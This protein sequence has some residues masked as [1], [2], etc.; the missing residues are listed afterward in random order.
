MS[1]YRRDPLNSSNKDAFYDVGRYR[2]GF[3][4]V[5]LLASYLNWRGIMPTGKWGGLYTKAFIM[6]MGLSINLLAM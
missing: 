6:I 4:L 1:Q 3:P 2:H 5:Y